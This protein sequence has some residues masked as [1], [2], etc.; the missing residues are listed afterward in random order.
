MATYKVQAPDGHIIKV[1]GPDGASEADV[2]ANAQQLYKPKSTPKGAL[3]ALIANARAASSGMGM[4]FDDELAA[5]VKTV[6]PIS[7]AKSGYTEG[8]GKAY[9]ENLA[10]VR[11]QDAA[12]KAEHPVA[13]GL[14][15]VEGALGGLKGL[16]LLRAMFAPKAVATVRAAVPAVEAASNG[17]RVATPAVVKTMAAGAGYGAVSGAGAGDTMASRQQSAATGALTGAVLGGV[18]HG[19]VAGAGPIIK[20]YFDTFMGKGITQEALR[21]IRNAL[22]REGYDV[23]STAGVNALKT[24]LGRY[25]GKPVSLA[26]MGV[27]P[28]ARAAV[29]VRTPNAAQSQAIDTITAR[30][31]GQ[32]ARLR[33]DITATVAPRTDVHALDQ[34]LVEQRATEAL[35]LKQAALYKDNP[36]AG[37]PTTD[38]VPMVIAGRQLNKNLVPTGAQGASV[39]NVP[40]DPVLQQLARLPMAQSALKN[41]RDITTAERDRL[42]VTGGDTSHLPDFPEQGANLDMRALDHLKRALDDEVRSAYQSAES[43]VRATAPQLQALRDEIRDR[44]RAI[45]PEYGQYLDQFAGTSEL[46]DALKAGR[47][48]SA[49][50]GSRESVPGF[51]Q[52]DPE[53]IAAEQAKRSEAGQEFYRVGAARRLTDI[54]NDTP[55]SSYPASRLLNSPESRAQL[56]A[57]GVEPAAQAKLQNS[58]DLEQTLNLLPKSI[59]SIGAGVSSAAA[60]DAD[61]I[62]QVIPSSMM[63]PEHWLAGAIRKTVGTV[64][65]ARNAKINE[66][67]LPRLLETNPQAVQATINDLVS[68][69]QYEQ[70]RQLAT[71]S[72]MSFAARLIGNV[73]G[74]PVSVQQGN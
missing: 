33:K 2:L 70:A 66:A 17:V 45:S 71:Q 31:Q 10:H 4:N 20:R 69:G 42:N 41:A 62:G 5:G 23:T 39:P 60:Q 6:L 16:G 51:D 64:N 68:N 9:Q 50:S 3:G 12:Y 54:V 29:G 44:M 57:T 46:R 32:G 38:Q 19:T 15:T 14:G 27:N 43:G 49:A 21:Q 26:D 36:Q 30:T 65:L 56:A 24:E 28:R 40:D 18:I 34:A 63:R 55:D 73:A 7:N 58:V 35:P 53:V 48:A 13:S 72:K 74:S 1:E 67:V 25:V 61:A 22:S 8:F 52:M 11:G 37:A 59:R 47:G